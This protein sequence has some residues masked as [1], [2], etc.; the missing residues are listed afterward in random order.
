MEAR[1][2]VLVKKLALSSPVPKLPIEI[3][4]TR[5]LGLSIA[6]DLVLSKIRNYDISG[7]GLLIEREI[8]L[9]ETKKLGISAV[10]LLMTKELTLSRTEELSVLGLSF[11]MAKELAL[12]IAKSPDLLAIAEVD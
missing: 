8:V 2:D 3:S 10:G 7:L 9:L 1:L 6:R 11:L 5:V 4:V 12:L